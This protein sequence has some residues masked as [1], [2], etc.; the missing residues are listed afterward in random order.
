MIGRVD[1]ALS[2]WQVR[3]TYLEACNCDP[4]C[5]CRRIGGRDG[6]RSTHGDCLGALSW[7][8]E[9]GHAAEIDLG[10]LAVVLTMSY[11]DDEEG[12]PWTLVLHVDD[13]GDERQRSALEEVFLG[14]LGGDLLRL[15]WVRKP[16][17]SATVRASRIEID[18]TPG[19]GWFRAG[20]DVLVRVSGPVA[21]EEQ[22]TCVVPG[23]D[24][25]GR[26]LHAEVIEVDDPPLEFALHDRCAFEARFEY[27]S[28][29]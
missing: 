20:G 6:G 11:S 25:P 3:G 19:R 2:P 15:P 8:I 7:L 10:R 23:H 29:S 9:D 12:S 26:E 13:R 24:H 16:V 4:I 5:P 21:T 28:S 27:R 22:V 1:G 14:R 17:E 18:H